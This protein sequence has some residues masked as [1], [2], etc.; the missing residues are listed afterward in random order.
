[1]GYMRQLKPAQKARVKAVKEKNGIEAAIRLA[2][3]LAR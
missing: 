2:R 3:K 1:M